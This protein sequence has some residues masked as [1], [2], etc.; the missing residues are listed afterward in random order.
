[1]DLILLACVLAVVFVLGPL[2]A[3]WLFSGYAHRCPDCEMPRDLC[4]CDE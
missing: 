3:V 2:A 4:E 1:M